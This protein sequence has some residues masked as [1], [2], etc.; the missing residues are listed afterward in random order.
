MSGKIYEEH[1]AET[2]SRYPSLEQSKTD[3]LSAFH[4]LKSS[5]QNGRKLLVC[6][7][8]GS[9]ADSDHIVGEL[10]NRFAFERALP[11]HLKEALSSGEAALSDAVIQKLQPSLRAISLCSQPALATAISNDLGYDLVY[12]QQVLGYGDDGDVL[13]AISTSGN[14]DNVVCAV[15]VAKAKGLKTIALTGSDGGSL[16]ALCDI[17]ICVPRESTA[18][19]QELHMPVYHTLCRMLEADFFSSK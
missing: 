16:K 2:L 19:I 7:N 11:K 5:F 3:I 12:A 18:Q 4:A 14:S 17:S 15:K 9:A 13:L 1:L 8:G 10:M 6:G